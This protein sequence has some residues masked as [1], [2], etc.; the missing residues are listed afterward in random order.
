MPDGHGFQCVPLATRAF[1]TASVIPLHLRQQH[2]D[3]NQ[4]DDPADD[5]ERVIVRGL[6]GGLVL[7]LV[8]ALVP[9]VLTIDDNFTVQTPIKP[10]L[11]QAGFAIY[12]H[13]L[14]IYQS[15]GYQ[16]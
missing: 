4:Q 5:D 6:I 12:P 7:G 14:G 1:A 8:G 10:P 9:L 11:G 2:E 15:Y 16:A 13:A 3:H